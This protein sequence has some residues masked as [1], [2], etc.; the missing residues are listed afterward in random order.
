MTV[1]KYFNNAAE[2]NQDKNLVYTRFVHEFQMVFLLSV[3]FIYL[4]FI[5]Q[6]KWDL[7]LPGGRDPFQSVSPDL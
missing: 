5:R 3:A 4:T 2:F 6:N 7:K 1:N